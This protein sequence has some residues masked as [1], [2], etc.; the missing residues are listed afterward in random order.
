MINYQTDKN[1]IIAFVE[2][3]CS[4]SNNMG[5]YLACFTGFTKA[6]G[7][8]Y[9]DERSAYL[10]KEIMHDIKL[11]S[12]FNTLSKDC[13]GV[14]SPSCEECP[15]RKYCCEYILH[16][17]EHRVG[18]FA[19]VDL[20]CGAGGLSLGFVQEGFYA[21]LAN[22]IEACCVDTYAHNHPETPRDHII[23][24]DIREVVSQLESLV[25]GEIIDIVVGGPPCQGFSMANRQ[26]LIDDPRNYLYKNYI[27]VVKRLKPKFFVMEN[28]KGMLGVSSQVKEDF[29]KIGYT[30]ECKVFNASD[31]GVP[32]NRERLIYIGNRVG[33]DNAQIISEIDAVASKSTPHVLIDAIQDL[34]PLKAS[35]SKN[36]TEI[37]NE[38]SGS[39]ISKGLD[40]KKNE[41]V[42]I[43]NGGKLVPVI[44][45]HKARYNN[46]RDIEIYGRL[47]QGD[48]SDDPK[49]ADIMPYT[50]RNDIFKDKYFK[51]E[52]NKVCKTITAHMKF[53]C[54]MYIHP[55]QARGLT[56]REAARVQSYPDDYFFRG[57]YT[58]TY[59]QIG[60]SVPPILSRAIAS[61]LKKYLRGENN[62]L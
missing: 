31:F 59:M 22:D 60:N 33:I 19:M 51:L 1:E 13:N 40:G 24:G 3:G 11:K 62:E 34:K 53:D 43:I 46:D 6:T 29:E 27:E 50:S 48:R 18:Q 8:P 49:I 45:N 14:Y 44:C 15:V 37:D 57:S 12:A 61:V 26:R 36:S 54:N 42:T 4:P 20:F 10:K 38:E 47:F 32:Q 58:K 52:E 16:A 41:Y 17:R 55:T 5:D 35:R 28:V 2:C 21:T 9:L 56:P 39:K 7:E 30:V 23:Q 25:D